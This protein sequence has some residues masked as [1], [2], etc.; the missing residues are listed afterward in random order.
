MGMVDL[1]AESM[2][3][4]YEKKGKKLSFEL[5]RLVV[6]AETCDG[7]I[8]VMLHDPGYSVENIATFLSVSIS[9]CGNIDGPIQVQKKR[10]AEEGCDRLGTDF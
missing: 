2:V 8:K 10:R 5:A 6:Q 7:I 1:L 4:E 9:V 3:D